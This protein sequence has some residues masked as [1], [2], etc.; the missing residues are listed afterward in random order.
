MISVDARKAIH[1]LRRAL[2]SLS[3]EEAKTAISRAENRSI[4]I[5][6][7]EAR[8]RIRQIYNVK[9]GVISKSVKRKN[10]TKSD[11]TAAIMASEA[12]IQLAAFSPRQTPL[13]VTIKIK[14]NRIL[15]KHA[16]LHS[17]TK[18]AAV[19]ARGKYKGGDFDFRKKRN[20]MG[21]D[22]RMIN[23]RPV[24]IDAPD[25]PISQ[26]YTLSVPLMFQEKQVEKAVAS[27]I[28]QYYP[29]RLMHE[30]MYLLEKRGAK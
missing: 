6:N 3:P 11:L 21:K 19:F 28:E 7:T 20:V 14:S 25:M 13:G 1:D 12:N 26:L 30:I 24:P 22:F 27:K 15:I 9:A 29:E 4:S 2:A 8:K 18:G 10:A 5:A 23:G 16:F 17:T